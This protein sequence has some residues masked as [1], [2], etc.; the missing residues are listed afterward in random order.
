MK[1]QCRLL[2]KN[3]KVYIE[4]YGKV[5]AVEFNN[6]LLKTKDAVTPNILK[7][8]REYEEKLFST[9]TLNWLGNKVW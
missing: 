3:D 2:L 1:K 8:V 9:T 6:R 7:E 5:V 4:A